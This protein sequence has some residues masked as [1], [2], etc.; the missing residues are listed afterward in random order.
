MGADKSR[1]GWRS[2]VSLL[3][4]LMGIWVFAFIVGPWVQERIP[5]FKQIVQVA[6]DRDI[7]ASAY[8]Y[9]EINESYE[10]EQY[11]RES[12]KLGAPEQAGVTLPSLACIAL[13][14]IILWLGYRFLPMD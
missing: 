4:G 12:L 8:F 14:G 10:G 9:S 11:L 5:I 3:L 1:S 2:L 7:D 6:E 13:C